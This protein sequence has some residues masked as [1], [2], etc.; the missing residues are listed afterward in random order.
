VELLNSQQATPLLDPKECRDSYLCLD[1]SG[2]EFN[3]PIITKD[4]HCS[5]W[6]DKQAISMSYNISS[7]P[8]LVNTHYMMSTTPGAGN[9]TG[10]KPSFSSLVTSGGPSYFGFY[11]VF[12]Y[13]LDCRKL[14][15]E[16]T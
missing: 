14:I 15:D 10:G 3:K 9:L 7:S 5:D 6:K 11:Q 1:R 4:A 16:C 2:G 12:G 13:S 8:Q